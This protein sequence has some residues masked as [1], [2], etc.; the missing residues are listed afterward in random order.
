MTDLIGRL[1]AVSFDR[2][3]EFWTSARASDLRE[4][5][6]EIE[7]LRGGLLAAK[8][9]IAECINKGTDGKAS[10]ECSMEFLSH[11]P[12]ECA[13]VKRQR[14]EAR[15][16]LEKHKTIAEHRNAAHRSVLLRDI[17][18][19]LNG[20]LGPIRNRRDLMLL[21][22]VKWVLSEEDRTP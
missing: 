9:I 20:D 15:S 2:P 18:A 4:A 16:D 1:V 13:A 19:A 5:V 17:E 7:R 11:A 12:T 3:G 8:R 10:A 22:P 21:P 14:D 6:N